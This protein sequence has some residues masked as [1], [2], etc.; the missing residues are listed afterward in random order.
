MVLAQSWSTRRMRSA[1]RSSNRARRPS[2]TFGASSTIRYASTK[3]GHDPGN[4]GRRA[5]QDRDAGCAEA[6][7]VLAEPVGVVLGVLV[8]RLHQSTGGGAAPTAHPRV[9]PRHLRVHATQ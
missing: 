8:A 7:G 1:R 2:T 3:I 4:A 5:S 6:A 9:L